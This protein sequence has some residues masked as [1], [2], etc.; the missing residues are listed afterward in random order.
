MIVHQHSDAQRIWLRQILNMGEV[1]QVKHRRGSGVQY[2][3]GKK[4]S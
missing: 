1:A 4:G 2:R 3:E